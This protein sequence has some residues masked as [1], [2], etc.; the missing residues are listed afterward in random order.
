M[1]LYKVN[2]HPTLH[3]IF[4][5]ADSRVKKRQFEKGVHPSTWSNHDSILDWAI[6]IS[7]TD[8]YQDSL[9]VRR[10]I[11]LR[12]SILNEY[13]DKYSHLD[14]L[15][16][17]IHIPSKKISPGGY[18]LFSNLKETIEY[19]GVKCEALGWEETF[20]HKAT[21]FQPTIFFSSDN[22]IYRNKVDWFDVKKYKTKN[23]LLIGLT[24]TVEPGNRPLFKRLNWA[25]QHQIDFYYSFRSDEYLHIRKDYLPY[26]DEGFKIYSVEF[27]ANPLHYFPVSGCPKDLAYVFLASSNPDK[28]ARYKEWLLPIF[29]EHPGF[30]DG[31]GWS[32]IDRIADKSL[33]RY[34]Y[35][36]AKVG[37]N[38]HIDESIDWPSELNERAYILAACGVPQ[39]VD[40]AKLIFKRFS[41]ES[42]FH[43]SSP[44]EYRDLFHYI[45]EFPDKAAARSNLALEEVFAKH[46]TF[47]RAES[48]IEKL[49]EHF[50]GN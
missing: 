35:G 11:S 41:K 44:A 17:L 45:M 14:H 40:N 50:G 2:L 39:L 34:L 48:L 9:T 4:R 33:H 23:K 13:K 19:M 12:N 49:N 27:G 38:L 7:E 37:V 15:R 36:R 5:Y 6:N 20:S 42:I 18:S 1:E 3:R 22:E 28:Q 16:V 24:A 8:I 32:G 46:T 29:S 26:F 30:L 43:A 47:H 31:P 21:M 10:G 25:K